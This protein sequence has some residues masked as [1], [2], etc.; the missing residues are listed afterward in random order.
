VEFDIELRGRTLDLLRELRHN[1]EQAEPPPP[2]VD[3]PK[4]PRC[5]L[6]SICLPD[7]INLLRAA[8]EPAAVESDKVRR[9][10]PARDDALPLYVQSA[11]PRRPSR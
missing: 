11:V 2:L 3:S 6:V 7:E 5:S 10:I 8:A 9:L 4:C 1:A